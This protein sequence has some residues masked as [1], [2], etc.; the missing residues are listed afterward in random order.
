MEI[1]HGEW[2][3]VSVN[4][5]EI[6]TIMDFSVLFN[7]NM[8]PAPVL[9]IEDQKKLILEEKYKLSGFSKIWAATRDEAITKTVK[10]YNDAKKI[11]DDWN[12]RDYAKCNLRVISRNKHSLRE[13]SVYEANERRRQSR[14][15]SAEFIMKEA[16]NDLKL[17]LLTEQEINSL[18]WAKK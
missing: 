3:P 9:S 2:Q 18:L 6:Q 1:F 17:L 15:K 7:D 11:R 13:T 4:P 14:I 12:S 16:I 5:A 8:E 10:A